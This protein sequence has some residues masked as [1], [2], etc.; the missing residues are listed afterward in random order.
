MPE[1]ARNPPKPQ[2]RA[3]RPLSNPRALKTAP[4][5]RPKRKSR[6]RGASACLQLYRLTTP[7]GFASPPRL[8]KSRGLRWRCTALHQKWGSSTRGGSF[9]LNKPPLL[10]VACNFGARPVQRLGAR[11][12][13]T[14]AR[15]GRV[16]EGGPGD[17]VPSRAARCCR[18]RPSGRKGSTPPPTR[19]RRGPRRNRGARRRSPAPP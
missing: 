11:A 14:Q 2:H 12:L 13:L 16:L 6:R 1:S 17:E 10:V 4:V 19:S 18:P 15:R 8:A 9:V 5:A 7:R 3:H